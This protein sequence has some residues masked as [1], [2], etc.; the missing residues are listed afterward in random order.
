MYCAA[1][2]SLGHILYTFIHFSA[3]CFLYFLYFLSDATHFT[4]HCIHKF[5]SRNLSFRFVSSFVFYFFK[6]AQAQAEAKRKKKLLAKAARL[7][8]C[9]FLISHSP[10]A[11]LPPWG[12]E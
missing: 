10:P 3:S 8:A 4:L 6:M 5:I 2:V 9:P 1:V 12:N 11:L 7:L